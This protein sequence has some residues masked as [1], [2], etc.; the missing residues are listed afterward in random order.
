MDRIIKRIKGFFRYFIYALRTDKLIRAFTI[1]FGVML[2]LTIAYGVNKKYGRYEIMTPRGE[3]M[4]PTFSYYSIGILDKK[5][6]KIERYDVV[7][8]DAP[9]YRG[10]VDPTSK[11]PHLIDKR[12][13][14]LPGETIRIDDEG[15]IY[16]NGEIIDDPYAKEKPFDPGIASDEIVLGDDEYFM[17]GDNRNQSMDSRDYLIGWVH[18]NNIIGKDIFN[19]N[20]FDIQKN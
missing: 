19:I 15:N 6:E 4:Q 11:K 16:I 13:Y 12:V 10:F 5:P 3:S 9:V 17:L 20:I 2:L 1:A 7:V 14:G 8:F 18:G